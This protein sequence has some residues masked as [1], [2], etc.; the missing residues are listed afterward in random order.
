MKWTKYIDVKCFLSFIFTCYTSTIKTLGKHRDRLVLCLSGA[1]KHVSSRL[2]SVTPAIITVGF[3]HLSF[4]SIAVS[5]TVN[6]HRVIAS[7][8]SANVDPCNSIHL[9]VFLHL[10]DVWVGHSSNANCTSLFNK[11]QFKRPNVFVIHN[12]FLPMA[13]FLKKA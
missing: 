5:Q 1:H 10:A 7:H 8:S 4:S 6:K 12:I 3:C 13:V 2:V 9:S 11:M